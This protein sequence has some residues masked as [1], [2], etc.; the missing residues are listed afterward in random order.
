MR[1]QSRFE[2]ERHRSQTQS[3]LPGAGPRTAP[4]PARI[5]RIVPGARSVPGRSKVRRSLAPG[6]FQPLRLS[7]TSLGVSEC[8]IP[9][10]RFSPAEQA[11]RHG[12]ESWILDVPWILIFEF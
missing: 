8:F 11:I 5:V 10:H 6:E 1:W 7:T 2:R 12:F 4:C 3:D 9:F